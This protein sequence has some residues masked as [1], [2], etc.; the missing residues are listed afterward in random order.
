M[1]TREEDVDAHALRRQG[2]KI[3]AIA[4]HLG[5][6]RKTISTYLN[7]E[8]EAGQ[9]RQAPDAVVPFLDYCRQRLADNPHQGRPRSSSSANCSCALNASHPCA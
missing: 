2:W 1:L 5:R 3:S 9:R 8:V 6:D 7:G 4:R